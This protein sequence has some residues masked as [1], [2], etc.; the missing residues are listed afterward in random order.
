MN[1]D[2]LLNAIDREAEDSYGA[3]ENSALSTDRALAI[4]YY[5]GKNTMPAPEGR[6]QVVDRSVFETIN[7]VLPSIVDI[8]ANG[9]DVIALPPVGPEDVEGAR[10][11][12]QYLNHVMLNKSPWLE[13][14]MTMAVDSFL[15]KNA[16]VYVYRDYKRNVDIETYQR[17]TAESL[18]MLL[19]DSDVEIID[20]KSYPDPDGSMSPVMGEDG[21]PVMQV[22]GVDPVGQPLLQP[23]M[24]PTPLYDVTIRRVT[25]TGQY[26]IDVLPPE[27]CKISKRTPTFR[28]KD[29][30]YFEYEC[31]VTISDLRKMG[32]DVEDDIN[33]QDGDE[34]NEDQARNQYNETRDDDDHYDPAC[35][36][37][38]LRKVWIE[39]DTDEDGIAE[40]Q[41]VMRVGRTVLHREEIG[42]IPVASTVPIPLPHRHIGM[43]LADITKD[44][45]E[46][47]TAIM[48][49]G[50]D[51]LYLSNNG[52]VGV[53][54]KVSIDDVLVSR[55]GQPMRVD[56]D[57]PDVAGHI[58][59]VVTPFIF[60]QAM[61][62]IA[63]MNSVRERR[64]G[65][66]NSFQGLDANALTQLQP[67]T[68]NQISS[69]AAQRV[70]LLARI[71]GCCIEDVASILHEVILKAG[72]KKE[73]VELRG[74]FVPVDPSQWKKRTD[75][76]TVVG[77]AAG[78]KDAMISRLMMIGNM[79]KEALIGGLPIVMPENVYETATEIVK[80]ADFASPERFF[81]DPRKMPPKAPPQPDVTVVAM[82]KIKADSAEK[83][84]AAE[85]QQK[86]YECEKDNATKK[87]EIDVESQTRL[88]IA[89]AQLRNTN[90]MEARKGEREAGMEHL[91]ASLNPK[92]VEAQAKQSEVKQ[93]EQLIE[94]FM[95]SQERQTAAIAAM[96]DNMLNALKSLN[97]P[98]RLVR[99][100]AGRA[101]GVEPLQ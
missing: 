81:T 51:N 84:K 54:N 57:L 50:L 59:P 88:A 41:F 72:H 25:K 28:L 91:R 37:V 98:K 49:G 48:R 29:C 5:L 55:P 53:S 6:S 39:Y 75:F 79:Q 18:T 68:V 27:R 77:Y 99:D 16:Y 8:F 2:R 30:P 66:N 20:Q 17:Q 13:I 26:C 70:K 32:F 1:F 45:Q 87:Y 36:V 10:Q 38:R 64:T 9:D 63:F 34:T 14:I 52:R 22:A 90:D 46:I 11:E 82:E 89:D 60:P 69:M 44:L 95:Q 67:G 97:G 65:V 73:V 21:Q 93:K 71:F 62:G 94:Q 35:R 19:D 42:R 4:K 83:I 85:I 56:T 23:L 78:N 3:D 74:N 33:D 47:N 40:M 76:K 15:T 43:S 58:H 24:Q 12:A 61:E 92:T 86:Q 101:V 31:E 80:A 7:W 96:F 100:K